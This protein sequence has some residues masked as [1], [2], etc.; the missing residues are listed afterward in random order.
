MAART[1]DANDWSP[2][3][4]PWSRADLLAMAFWTGLV[5]FYFWEVVSLRRALFY[6]DITELNF[7]YRDFFANEL[8]AGRFSRWHPGLFCGMPLFSESQAGYLHPFK[9]LFY[10]WM[11]NWKAFGLDCVFSVWLAG[12]ATYGW[13]R[14]HVRP[15]G[16][17]AGAV[18]FGFGGFMWAHFIHTSMLN[19]LPSVPLAFWALECAWSGGRLR[20]AVLGAIALA[21]QILAGHLQDFLLTS[22]GLGVYTA[23][24]AATEKTWGDRLKVGSLAAALFGLAVMLSAVQWVPSKELLD[25]SPRAGGLTWDQLTFGSWHPE[26]LPTLLVR[27]AY[28]TRARDTDW[29]DGF[30]P[31]H[32]MNAYLGLL[33]P[34]LA[35]LGAAG[36]RRDRWAA[37]WALF[38]ILA[39]LLMLG[40]YT[41]VMDLAHRIPVLGSSRIPVRFHLW[42]TLAVAALGAVG[43]D[44]MSRPGR[45]RVGWIFVVMG[46]AVVACVPILRWVYEPVWAS[47]GDWNSAYH[48]N[49]FGW[50]ER[51]L[52]VG[53]GRAVG[54]ALVGGWILLRAARREASRLSVARMV[55]PLI[56]VE[57][58]GAHWRDVPTVDPS[59]WTV[60]PASA[61]AIAEDAGHFRVSGGGRFSAGEPGYASFDLDFAK[62]RD[63]LAWSLAPVYGLP[64]VYGATPMVT[65]RWKDYF[66]SGAPGTVANDLAGVTHV[67]NGFNGRIPGWPDPTLHGT[68]YVFRS[69][70]AGPRVRLAGR[71]V[72]ASSREEAMRLFGAMGEEARQRIVVEDPTKPLA[73]D[74]MPGGSA[75]IERDEPERVVVR[76][77][78]HGP[79][80]LLMMDTYDPGWSATMDGKPVE[81]RPAFVNFRA[82]F[83]PDGTHRV[84]FRYEPAGWRMGLSLSV[85]GAL[86][87]SCGLFWRRSFAQGRAEHD[88]LGWPGWWPV[89]AVVVAGLIVVVSAIHV[90][91][92]GVEIHSRW[93]DSWH[94][95]TWGAGLEAMERAPLVEGR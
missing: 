36:A 9:Y 28:G 38:A 68:A 35:M 1:D 53:V 31:Y 16:A 46:A 60:P 86:L 69:P 76:V 78:T 51:E 57:L 27:E 71:P 3:P 56:A 48:R 94:R 6:F 63:T 7:P 8:K 74:A 54:V 20:G 45:L 17:M 89:A 49:R 24:R 66:D 23:Y 18:V 73:E 65:R 64:S 11:E 13:L 91:A 75:T 19:A 70:S 21:C 15:S 33:A 58:L 26:L 62:A 14:R 37:F 82:V 55:A 41:F 93:H 42:L 34:A 30:Y 88:R 43:V 90:S 83:V 40:K 59:Y 25:R 39:G 81:I 4:G 61:K 72:Y 32:E 77:H 5:A 85:I 22:L 95:F 84:E 50:L 12:A 87:G 29:M 67:L 10:P 47:P 79:S 2:A 92:N 52:M 80:Y 44:R